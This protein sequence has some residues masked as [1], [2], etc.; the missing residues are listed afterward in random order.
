MKKTPKRT[1][2]NLP[3][4]E[5]RESAISKYLE[6]SNM[7]RVKSLLTGKLRKP[8]SG[9]DG[10]LRV[11][12]IQESRTYLLSNLVADAFIGPRPWDHYVRYKDGD[13]TNCRVENLYYQHR[14]EA[15]KRA[16]KLEE[17]EP[18]RVTDETVY[19]IWE[20]IFTL[21]KSDIR[22]TLRV[23][24]AMFNAIL[25][26]GAF[27]HVDHPNRDRWYAELRLKRKKDAAKDYKIKELLELQGSNDLVQPERDSSDHR[28]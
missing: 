2:R 17:V 7:G 13:V 10:Y 9:L 22:R 4:E 16:S 18:I 8:S 21:R 24:K 6:V 20:Y 27:H 11:R 12:V 1:Y 26:Y 15:A 28:S 19:K 14:N 23:H 5:W 25:Y 3:N